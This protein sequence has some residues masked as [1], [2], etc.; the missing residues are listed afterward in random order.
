MSRRVRKLNN[1]RTDAFE[2]EGKRQ[3]GLTV[4]YGGVDKALHHFP[5]RG[6]NE[7]IATRKRRLFNAEQCFAAL[8]D[9]LC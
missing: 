8:D 6:V 9:L 7:R 4:S 3:H 1:G 2:R 5:D